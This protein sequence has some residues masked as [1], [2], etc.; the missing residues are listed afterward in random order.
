MNASQVENPSS[1]PRVSVSWSA[2]VIQLRDLDLFGESLGELCAAFVR[3]AFALVE[4]KWV[5]IDRDR[6][7]AHVGYDHG[8]CALPEFLKR[9]ATADLLVFDH[10]LALER[11]LLELD[12]V[13]VFP[14]HSE[15]DLLRYAAAAFRDL[16]DERSTALYRVCI[17]RDIKP[18]D[19]LP[20][21]FAAD[22]TLLHGNDCVKVGDLG[23]SAKG[24]PN[25]HG[26]E[27]TCRTEPEPPDSL[28]VGINGRVGGLIRFRRSHRFGAV[29]ALRRLRAKGNPQIGIVSEDPRASLASLA[30]SLGTNFY[31]GNQRPDGRV[32]WLRSCR[33][34]GFKV[35][36]VGDCR[37]N[38]RTVDEAQLAISLVGSEINGLDQDPAPIWLLQPRQDH[39]G[40]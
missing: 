36:Y 38:Q 39:S 40:G 26:R 12:A 31:V 2:G 7:T 23:S 29:S 25:P 11:A 14:G 35:A 13:Q 8:R 18:L 4:V 5:E 27:V 20:A 33:R 16:S 37:N 3:H 28:M 24:F 10:H 34:R 22:V 17:A 19:L 30:E 21:D 9:L 32:R 15:E 1:P 6:S